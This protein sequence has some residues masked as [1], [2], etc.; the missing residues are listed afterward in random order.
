M[1]PN[2]P[3]NPIMPPPS[4]MF[5]DAGREGA[6]ER[7]ISSAGSARSGSFQE[8]DFALPV[9][10]NYNFDYRSGPMKANEERKVKPDQEKEFLK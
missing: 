7:D 6:N 9:K 2:A 3:I 5:R 10:K 4:M 8:G 1:K